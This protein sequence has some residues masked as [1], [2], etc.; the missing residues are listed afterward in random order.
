MNYEAAAYD[1]RDP[2]A[3][4]FYVT[5]DEGSGPLVR[6]TPDTALVAPCVADANGKYNFAD[7][8][9]MLY[10]QN[11]GSD[12][13]IGNHQHHYFEVTSINPVGNNMHIGTYQWTTSIDAGRN[14]AGLYHSAGEGIDIKDGKIYYTTKSSKFLFIIDLDPNENGDLT[15]VR[16]STVSGAFDGQPDQVARVLNFET[17]ATDGILYFCE[18][19]GTG[20]FL[21]VG[22]L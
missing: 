8:S 5:V 16:S 19:G 9:P 15:F 12:S 13:S 4:T 3:P 20:K 22:G 6:F 7:C 1:N 18:D 17:G 14:S 21:R 10:D 2:T 11:G